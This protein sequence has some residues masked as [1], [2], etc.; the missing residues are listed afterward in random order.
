MNHWRFLSILQEREYLEER[1]RLVM[2]GTVLIVLIVFG[3]CAAILETAPSLLQSAHTLKS[4]STSGLSPITSTAWAWSWATWIVYGVVIRDLPVFLHNTLGFA[5]S[6][7]VVLVLTNNR[8]V[9]LRMAMCVGLMYAVLSVF[10]LANPLWGAVALSAADV[11][12]SVPQLRKALKE[13][14]LSGLSRASWWLGV[15]TDLCWA[16]YAVL[17][18]HPV[19]A[20]WSFVSLVFSA[21]VV[22]QIEHKSRLSRAT[23]RVTDTL[24]T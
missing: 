5:S 15:L 3:V 12:M 8:M 16:S 10:I 21:L 6:I 20:S 2:T 7:L 19:A 23:I 13:S 9:R 11:F 4:R 18:G 1:A 14:D 24:N 17:S 22:F